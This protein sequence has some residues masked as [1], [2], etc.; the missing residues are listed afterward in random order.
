MTK[1]SFIIDV[2]MLLTVLI[3][4]LYIPIHLTFEI[5]LNEMVGNEFAIM[6]PVLYFSIDAMQLFTCYYDK[7]KL[8]RDRKL[9]V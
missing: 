7:G 1:L 5:Y 4:F 6:L 2:I 9:I 3:Y 8:V